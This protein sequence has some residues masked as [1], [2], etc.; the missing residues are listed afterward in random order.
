VNRKCPARNT[1][2]QL[3]TAYTDPERRNDGDTDR[4]TDR[5]TDDIMMPIADPIILFAVR[6]AKNNDYSINHFR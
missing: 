3:L 2:V 6:S 1:T 5:Q 4:Q